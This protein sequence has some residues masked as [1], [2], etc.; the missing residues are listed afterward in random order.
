MKGTNGMSMR[1]IIT[2]DEDKCTGCGICIPNC[3]EGAIQ[4]IEGKARLISDLFCDGLGVCIGACPEGALLIE[5][6]EAE[7]YDESKVMANVVKNGEAVIKAHLEHLLEH[8]EVVYYKEANSYL[9]A[10]NIK[11]PIHNMHKNELQ[12]NN[13]SGCPGAIAQSFKQEKTYS[14]LSGNRPSALRN[15]PIQLHLVPPQ[16]PYFKGADFL[17]A[18]DCVSYTVG[19]FHK[20]FINGKSLAIACPK[21]DNAQDIYISKL[22]DIIDYGG[23]K[24][25]IVI[26]MEVPCCGGLL[27]IALIA[28]DSASRK[29]P[30]K[31]IKVNIK[32]DILEERILPNS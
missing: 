32:G 19:D 4:I 26:I 8:N 31:Y 27:H 9:K 10:N 1:K 7:H 20:D 12:N 21:L 24:S 23:I 11:V 18:A 28:A 3:P 6:R 13:H 15:W 14:D 16:A 22:K 30:V 29:I 25:I 2:I 5:E 17:L